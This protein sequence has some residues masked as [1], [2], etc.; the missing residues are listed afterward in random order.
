MVS[1]RR[2]IRTALFIFQP[3]SRSPEV[4]DWW[5][6]WKSALAVLGLGFLFTVVDW[7]TNLFPGW[8]APVI[9]TLVAVTTMC[10]YAVYRLHVERRIP[11][12]RTALIEAM[13]HLRN[14]SAD[15]LHS[16]WFIQVV[17]RARQEK[18]QSANDLFLGSDRIQEYE[19]AKRNL[20]L[21]ELIAGPDFKGVLELHRLRIELET[22]MCRD[23]VEPLTDEQ[24]QAARKRV[25][26]FADTA[27]EMLDQGRLYMP[28]PSASRKAKP[29]R[30][31]TS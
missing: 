6:L 11:D 2:L 22:D 28:K 25:W 16:L 29:Q 4:L 5:S 21:Q 27:I 9:G 18:G 24:Y 12:N 30:Q 14:V 10:F 15:L 19:D 31:S 20:E 13:Y 17:K 8:S 3:L 26:D 1:R 23:P 7:L